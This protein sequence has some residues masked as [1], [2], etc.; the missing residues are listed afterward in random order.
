MM[1]V[2]PKAVNLVQSLFGFGADC[3]ERFKQL[4]FLD[5]NAV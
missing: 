2:D 3:L 4:K 5:F 1:I